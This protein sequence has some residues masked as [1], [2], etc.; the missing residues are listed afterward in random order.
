[1]KLKSLGKV[2]NVLLTI[3]VLVLIASKVPM[4]Y[5][6]FAR[7]GQPVPQFSVMTHN[8]F[9]FSDK[10]ITSKKILIFWATWCPPCELELSR[11][12][13]LVKEK[14]IPAEA[15]L[16]I[17]IQEEKALVDRTAIERGYEFPVG[18]DFDGKVSQTFAV[19]GTPTIVFLNE[20]K[21]IRWITTGLSPL[22]KIRLRMFLD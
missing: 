11:I 10:D 20:D 14:R 7:E 12:N 1:V 9:E 18:Y 3:S 15:I 17:S 6:H 22:L 8:D 5:S 2:L 19:E 21:T 16:A 13:D 4:I